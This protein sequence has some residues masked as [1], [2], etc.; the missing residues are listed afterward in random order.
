MLQFDAK[1]DKNVNSKLFLFSKTL[2]GTL[3]E[4]LLKPILTSF[5]RVFIYFY[6]VMKRHVFVARK[7]C[8][9]FS[10]TA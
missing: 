1:I 5:L 4:A 8:A 2:K 10:H 7:H 6:A 3:L 9:N